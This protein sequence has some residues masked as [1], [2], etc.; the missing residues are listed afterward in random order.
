MQQQQ[1]MEEEEGERGETGEE[2]VVIGAEGGAESFYQDFYQFPTPLPLPRISSS[3]DSLFPFQKEFATDKVA[4]PESL[5]SS[6]FP[7]P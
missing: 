1:M 2:E 6:H 3:S 7:K 5:K 4:I